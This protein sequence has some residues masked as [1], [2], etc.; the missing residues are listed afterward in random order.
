MFSG[1]KD[2][3]LCDW[4]ILGV[5]SYLLIYR[6]ITVVPLV[7]FVG[8]EV[9]HGSPVVLLSLVPSSLAVSPSFLG[10]VMP[11]GQSADALPGYKLCIFP[12]NLGGGAVFTH[13]LVLSPGPLGKLTFTRH[14]GVKPFI[15][16]LQLS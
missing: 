11:Q 10:P 1:N 16:P 7:S 14:L 13:F 6:P 9:Q 4:W 15:F 12:R 3:L 5:I 8:A 2:V